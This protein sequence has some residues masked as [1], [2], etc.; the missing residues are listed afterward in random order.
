MANDPGGNRTRITAKAVFLAF[1]LIAGFF[2]VTEHW[3]HLYG[4]L[5]WLLLLACPVLHLILH[6]GHGRHGHG[7]EGDRHG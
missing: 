3:A 2:L 7:A 5:P 6:R 1:L 4:A